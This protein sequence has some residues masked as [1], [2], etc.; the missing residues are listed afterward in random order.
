M[1]SGIILVVGLGTYRGIDL[2]SSVSGCPVEEVLLN[3][4]IATLAKVK[5]VPSGTFFYG[6]STSFA[7]LRSATMIDAIK[8]A[9][10]SFNLE[11]VHPKDKQ[12]GSRTGIEML[13]NGELNFAQSSHTL[14][15]YELQYATKKGFVLEQRAVAIEGIAIYVHSGLPI[16]GLTLEQVQQIFAGEIT[17]WQQVGGPN[18]KITVFINPKAGGLVDFFQNRVLVG[19]EFGSFQEVENATESLNKVAT[20][21]G[22]IGYTTASEVVKQKTVPVKLLPLA[23]ST[24]KPYVPP[25]SGTNIDM[26]NQ[27][28]FTDDS[29]PITRKLYVIIKKDGGRDEQA[30]TAYANLL[31]SVEGQELV[32]RA[33]FAPIRPL[34]SK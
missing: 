21:P 31:L 3:T 22:G 6:G 32:E 29:Y 1:L 23:W 2:L 19:N 34:S 18:L 28:A 5:N 26:V 24:D 9:H 33:G 20:T 12:P 17:N 25:F 4:C 13:L 16:R 15:P 27:Q 7:P 8:Q 30:G 10:P 11:Y 14:K